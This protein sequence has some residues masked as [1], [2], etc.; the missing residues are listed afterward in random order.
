MPTWSKMTPE[1]K[2]AQREYRRKWFKQ[3]YQNEPEFRERFKVINRLSHQRRRAMRDAQTDEELD[4]KALI[5]LE[6]LRENRKKDALIVYRQSPI[7]NV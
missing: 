5:G 2:Q 7:W 3:R 6:M 4:A 1:Q